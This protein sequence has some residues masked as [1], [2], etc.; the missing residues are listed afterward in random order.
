VLGA[1]AE[2]LKDHNLLGVLAVALEEAYHQV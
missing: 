1:V 2:V